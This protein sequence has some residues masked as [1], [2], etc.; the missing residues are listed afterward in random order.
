MK[1]FLFFALFLAS[2][3]IAQAETVVLQTKNTTMVLNVEGD[4]QP[5]YVY[6][7]AK[8]SDYDL[9][10]LQRPRG[11]RMDAYPVY[12][13]NCPAEAALAMTHAD[14][15]LSSDMVA[16]GSIKKDGQTTRISMKDRVYPVTLDLCFKVYQNEDM[17]ETWAE[18]TNGEAKPVTLT[19]F[20][21]CSLP[22]RR[23]N[24]WLSSF[25]G[26]WGNE[27]ILCEEP[28]TPGEKIIKNKDGV[29]N[30]HTAHGE[31]MFSLD[32]KGQENAGDVIGAA[33]VYSGNYQLKV[34][35][36]DT[37]FHYFF[38]GI[39]PD[40]SYYH[41]KKGETFVTP[42]VALSFSK[43]GLSGVSRNFHKWGLPQWVA[44]SS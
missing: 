8:L 26:S 20:A 17:I 18:I 2:A 39:N 23:G 24:V 27:A 36:D 21:S 30:A 38:A 7:G 15:N 5:Q 14:G 42:A 41:L 19:Q 31:V 35:T 29:R 33:I 43:Q 11:G 6:Y 25:Y 1:K 4:K 34:E 28:L 9:Q 12:G 32:G 44:S 3:Q 13:M 40:N 37:D 16:T 10:N 22:I